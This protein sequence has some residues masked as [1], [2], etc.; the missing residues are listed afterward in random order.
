MTIVNENG[1]FVSYFYSIASFGESD[2]GS[3]FAFGQ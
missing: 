1:H 2:E 3:L